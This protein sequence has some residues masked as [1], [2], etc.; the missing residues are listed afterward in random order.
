MF[1]FVRTISYHNWFVYIEL[2]YLQLFT[3]IAFHLNAHIMLLRYVICNYIWEV[4]TMSYCHSLYV[5]YC[6]TYRL[7]YTSCMVT[8]YICEVCTTTFCACA[9]R[10]HICLGRVGK[11][12]QISKAETIPVEWKLTAKGVWKENRS[13]TL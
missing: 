10:L 7:F 12:I 1:A 9:L 11:N 5:N 6:H 13:V 8:Y 3:I 4:C 2:Y